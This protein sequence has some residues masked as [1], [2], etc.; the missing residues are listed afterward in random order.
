[1]LAARMDEELS[2]F[3]LEH[4]CDGNPIYCYYFRLPA[5][6]TVSQCS[7]TDVKAEILAN[8]N[9]PPKALAKNP[10]LIEKLFHQGIG[11]RGPAIL[12]K[13]KRKEEP[14]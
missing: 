3:D 12:N 4:F 2:E 9:T 8:R 5:L 11:A 6:Q 7:K 10:T 14:I 13:D 1:M